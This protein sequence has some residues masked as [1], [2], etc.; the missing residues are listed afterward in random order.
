MR[1]H[2][3]LLIIV[4]FFSFLPAQSI[5]VTW[6]G[7]LR[8]RSEADNRD[9]NLRSAPNLYT[10][11]RIRL[12]ANAVPSENITIKLTMQDSRTF[13]QEASTTANSAN[14]DLYEGSVKID[15]IFDTSISVKLGRMPLAY[16]SER[17]IGGLGWHNY[18]RVFDGIVLRRVSADMDI[19]LFAANVT[20]INTAP[21]SVNAGTTAYLYDKGIIMAGAYASLKLIDGL[22]FDLYAVHERNNNQSKKDT[23]DYAFTTVGGLIKGKSGQFFYDGEAAAQLGGAKKGSMSRHILPRFLPVHSLRDRLFLP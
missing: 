12:G 1:R 16:G 8:F 14:L 2:Y 21:A 9:F 19:D 10:L 18:S 17:I 13:G 22:P 3:I 6:N 7:E 5:P 23:V 4:L 11:S 15:S 20:D